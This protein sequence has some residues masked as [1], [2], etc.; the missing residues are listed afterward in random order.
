[1]NSDADP[2]DIDQNRVR[3]RPLK[4]LDPDP[5]TKKPNPDHAKYL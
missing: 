4:K 5:S 3:I 1:M 2:S